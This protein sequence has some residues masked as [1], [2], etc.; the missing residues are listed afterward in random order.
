MA[1]SF[2]ESPYFLLFHSPAL[3]K[4][5]ILF[6]FSARMST[7]RPKPSH[8]FFKNTIPP[9]TSRV[10]AKTCFDQA[11]DCF[12]RNEWAQAETIVDIGLADAPKN[13]DLLNLKSVLCA[14]QSRLD[15]AEKIMLRILNIDPAHIGSLSNL[16]N[17][18]RNTRRYALAEQYLLKALTLS[19]NDH[20]ALMNLGVVYYN[21]R[22]R[23]RAHEYYDKAIATGHP[24]VALTYFNKA[25][26]HDED[27]EHE[28]AIIYYQE[29][30]RH[31]PTNSKART[32]LLFLLSHHL[33]T[34]LQTAADEARRWG[35][36]LSAATPKC[37]LTND[38]NPN[39]TLR[40]GLLSGD[41]RRHPVSHFLRPLLPHLSSSAELFAYA[42]S[43]VADEITT[44]MQSYFKGWRT[45][46]HDSDA[47]VARHIMEDKIDVLIDLSGHTEQGRISVFTMKPAPVQ[48]SWL[49]YFATTGLPEMDYM[50]A[51]AIC[52]PTDEEHLF[53]EQV[54]RLPHSRLFVYRP[55]RVT[56]TPLPCL[57]GAPFTFGCFQN[58]RKINDTVLAAWGQIM[59][60]AP[61]AR[62]RIQSAQLEDARIKARFTERLL[63]HGIDT[64]RVAL[65]PSTPYDAFIDAHR[66]IDVLLDTF[67]YPGGT[68][69]V[70]SFWQ[71]VPTLTLTGT[72]ML[73]RQ[74]EQLLTAVGLN[75]WVC[76]NTEQYVQT[77]VRYATQSEA[78]AELAQLRPDLPTKIEQSP[79]AD[80]RQFAADLTD[81]IRHVWQTYCTD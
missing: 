51:D 77:A 12:K 7:K 54:I 30:L 56:S 21:L 45:I 46:V 20:D 32:N 43:L 37:T 71:G 19:P 67:P 49:G 69:T 72:G 50:L 5:G 10:D 14:Q 26:A 1:I 16:G 53:C 48:V 31:D 79:A 18:Y 27:D 81:A 66:E 2:G 35:Q 6:I 57:N 41:F 75:D 65:H 38:R 52:V 15:E 23:N 39:R 74:G 4:W 78:Q 40:V 8:P 62:L 73:A 36:V 44:A 58:L 24:K 11:Y 64:Q 3:L 34:S 13:I 68:T 80:A 61:Q 60:Q 76:H 47:T 29:T 25:R 63:T 55:E 17:L 22:Q 9:V 70:E 59:A 33:P 42:N 28:A